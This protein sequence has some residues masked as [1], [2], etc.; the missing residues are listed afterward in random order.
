[1]YGPD[2]MDIDPYS[3]QDW[4]AKDTGNSNMGEIKPEQVSTIFE[5]AKKAVGDVYGA[6]GAATQQQAQQ[7]AAQQVAQQKQFQAALQQASRPVGISF[8]SR[9][10]KWLILGGVA[11]VG[12][13]VFFT[14]RKRR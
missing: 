7:V 11:V 14:L 12:L 8:F 10:G 13:M 2:I 9:Y 3:I 4:D 5:S 1:M 6:Q